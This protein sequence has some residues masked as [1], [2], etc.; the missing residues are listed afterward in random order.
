MGA[1]EASRREKAT[2]PERSDEELQGEALVNQIL[3]DNLPRV[4]MLLRRHTREIVACNRAGEEVGAAAGKTLPNIW[5][6]RQAVP[7]VQ[8]TA[9][10]VN[11]GLLHPMAFWTA[12]ALNVAT[13]SARDR[14]GSYRWGVLQR[15]RKV[16][17]RE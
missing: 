15:G 13:A 14:F 8:R 12:L 2:Q 11:G 9:P 17:S 7:V 1:E 10:M 3:L 16:R 4:A 5:A 6:E